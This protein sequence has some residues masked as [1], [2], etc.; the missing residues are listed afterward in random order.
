[1]SPTSKVVR[2]ITIT[3]RRCGRQHA[4]SGTAIVAGLLARSCPV[5]FPPRQG[6]EPEAA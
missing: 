3:C 5:C 2:S 6:D 4:V 1:M